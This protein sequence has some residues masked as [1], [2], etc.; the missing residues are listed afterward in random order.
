MT[1][2]PVI[3]TCETQR[4]HLAKLVTQPTHSVVCV[5]YIVFVLGRQ[6]ESNETRIAVANQRAHDLLK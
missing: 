6:G 2:T 1:C 4:T 3:Y 5:F